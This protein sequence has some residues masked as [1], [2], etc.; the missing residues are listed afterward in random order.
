MNVAISFYR[1]ETRRSRTIVPADESII[2]IAAEPSQTAELKDQLR[3][4]RGF[5]DQLDELDKAL[6][7]LYLDGNPYYVIAA[8]V[9]I[10]ESNVGTRINRIKQKLRRTWADLSRREHFHGIR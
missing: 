9:G 10:S 7:L 5:I 2:E 4:L 3:L 8:I 6:V 1:G